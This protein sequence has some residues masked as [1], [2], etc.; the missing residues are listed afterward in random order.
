M[1]YYLNK[2]ELMHYG[3][4]GQKWGIRR[5]QNPD[6]TL[7]SEGKERYR[8]DKVLN[9]I[10]RALT[11][12]SLGQRLAVNL[13]KG[14]RQDKKEIKGIYKEKKKKAKTDEERKSLKSDYKKTLGEARTAAAEANYSWQ[15]KETNKK[16]QTQHLGKQFL[17]SA[18]AGGF[19]T[20]VYDDLTAKGADRASAAVAG[21]FANM[22]DVALYGLI[23]IGDYAYGKSQSKKK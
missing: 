5:F 2:D 4:L 22:A 15:S 3:V 17:K 7:T 13:N 11:N 1:A 18:L 8:T 10:G 12:T 14:Y 19:G 6:G 21:I 23:D 20:K 9:N 16:I